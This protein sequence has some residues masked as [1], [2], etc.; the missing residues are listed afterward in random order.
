LTTLRPTETPAGGIELKRLRSRTRDIDYLV[1]F[2]ND[3]MTRK[4]SQ[5]NLSKSFAGDRNLYDLKSI[6]QIDLELRPRKH[7]FNIALGPGEGRILALISPNEYSEI[8]NNIYLKKASLKERSFKIDYNQT[9]LSGIESEAA[10]RA[11]AAYKETFDS[12]NGKKAFYEINNLILSLKQEKA[13]NRDYAEFCER[14]SNVKRNLGFL[15]LEG[16]YPINRK[17]TGANSKEINQEYMECLTAYKSGN[18][19][20]V[21]EKLAD[22]EKKIEGLVLEKKLN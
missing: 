10:E 9:T 4:T 16:L 18:W 20:V 22:L 5:F 1:A 15:A 14:L 8:E 3:C 2:N 13:Q 7:V 17:Y 6:S 21:S 19:K 11:Y 12:N